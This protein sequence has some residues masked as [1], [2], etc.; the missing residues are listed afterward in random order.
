MKNQGLAGAM[1]M[2]LANGA[3]SLEKSNRDEHA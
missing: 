3:G 2:I 1:A